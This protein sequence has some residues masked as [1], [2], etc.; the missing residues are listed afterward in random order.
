[1]MVSGGRFCVSRQ[2]ASANLSTVTCHSCASNASVSPVCM[3]YGSHP[4][5]GG[6]ST[7]VGGGVVEGEAVNVGSGVDVQGER[8]GKSVIVGTMRVG[9]GVRL[10]LGSIRARNMLPTTIPKVSAPVTMTLKKRTSDRVATLT[11][12]A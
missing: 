7:G 6:Q 8:V 2:L 5:G 12:D 4:R 11:S 3:A 1:M 10:A 9:R